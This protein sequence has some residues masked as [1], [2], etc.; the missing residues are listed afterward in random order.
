MAGRQLASSAIFGQIQAVKFE[1]NP[2][3]RI[4]WEE[5]SARLDAMTP[6]E[7]KQTFVDAGILTPKG[8]LTKPHRDAFSPAGKK[9]K[10]VK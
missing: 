1:P 8:R 10:K 3:P 5:A 9:A 4:L 2:D 7:R 6:E